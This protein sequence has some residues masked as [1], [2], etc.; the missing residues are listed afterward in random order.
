MSGYGA[1]SSLDY[2]MGASRAWVRMGASPVPL[3][4]PATNV[5]GFILRNAVIRCHHTANSAF[6]F[7]DTAAPSGV[8]DATKGWLLACGNYRAASMPF[9][10]RI[11]PGYGIWAVADAGSLST[12]N[13][14]YD[15][16]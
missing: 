14:D 4:L 16:L 13:I 8:D 7:L 12:A 9:P 2:A 1:K 6:L 10:R 3:I 5:N 11:R 15:L